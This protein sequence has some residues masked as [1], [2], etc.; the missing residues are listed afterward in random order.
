MSHQRPTITAARIASA[1]ALV[2]LI[3]AAVWLLAPQGGIP[4]LVSPG[5]KAKLVQ[6]GF[7][8]LEGPVGTADGGLYFTD[9]PPEK[10]Y[11]LDPGGQISL[12][13]EQSGKA[14]GLVATGDG[15]LLAAEMNNKRISKW[16]GDGT[17]TTLTD[18]IGGKPYMAP[19]DLIA[20][21]RGGI[22]FTDPGTFSEP[23]GTT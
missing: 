13:R 10:I 19:N 12:V 5:V 17:A 4:G 20:D 2:A 21:A 23:G 7:K 6:D 3:A 9:L 18:G 15:G 11:R 14:N 22:Y 8:F 16:S 1:V